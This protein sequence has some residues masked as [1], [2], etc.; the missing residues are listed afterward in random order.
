[1]GAPLSRRC[2]YLLTSPQGSSLPTPLAAAPL[3]NGYGHVPQD[4]ELRTG[5]WGGQQLLH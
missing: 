3:S 5:L 4:V 1:M 2:S